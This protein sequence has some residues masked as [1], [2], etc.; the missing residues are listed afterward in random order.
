VSHL[1]ELSSALQTA[2]N[3]EVINNWPEAKIYLDPDE[4][5]IDLSS[6]LIDSV[7]EVSTNKN[8]NPDESFGK[9]S[10]S[11]ITLKFKNDNNYFSPEYI[12]G[13]FFHETTKLYADYTHGSSIIE[14]PKNFN[15]KTGLK[16]YISDDNYSDNATILSIN[17]SDSNYD[18]ITF[19]GVLSASNDYSAGVTVETKYRVGDY[20]SIGTVL[21]GSGAPA[22][23]I[24]QYRGII[25]TLPKIDSNGAYITIQDTLRNLLSTQLKANTT[26]SRMNN[27]TSTL[28]SSL[29]YT[30]EDASIGTLTENSIN[31]DDSYCKIGSWNIEF[32]SATAF[33][34]TDP[35]GVKY[36][37][38]TGSTF[39]AGDSS[40]YQL[41]IA[42]S[43]W[44]GT[45][46]QGDEID[47][48]TYCTICYGSE[49]TDGNNVPKII[50]LLLTE[51]YGADFSASDYDTSAIASLKADFDDFRA[52]ITFDKKISVLKAI[53]IMLRHINAAIF[54]Q[55]SGPVSFNSYLP[56]LDPASPNELSPDTDIQDAEMETFTRYRRV[57][58][59]YDYSNGEFNK[60]FSY[61]YNEGEPHIEIKL[62]AFTADERIYAEAIVRRIYT[63]WEKGVKSYKI[64][65]KW[66]HGIGFELS[67]QF[68][69]SSDN[70]DLDTTIIEIFRINK[71]INRPGKIEAGGYD[72]SHNFDQYFFIGEHKL[73]N[74]RVVW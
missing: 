26:K 22:D 54:V 18:R 12:D 9:I 16:L 32:T 15:V 35:G 37:G 28:Q 72:I 43:A 64:R 67:D 21:K 34:V 5:N 63:M 51:D 42:T 20:I 17:T 73:S 45:F 19:T 52:G 2:L 74:G 47:F 13:P 62:P 4:D 39:Y 3:K 46:E 65:E 66:N 40:I 7:V 60:E 23:V 48:N 61:P 8:I 27:I 71:N 10:I 69:I 41:S 55:N 53:E 14:V 58:G 33:T 36:T 44:S 38:T 1:T 70:P 29:T 59:L 25:S 50:E 68:Q 24:D 57:M 30:R 6:R 49:G 31:I 11:E 56:Q